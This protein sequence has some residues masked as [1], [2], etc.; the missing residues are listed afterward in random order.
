MSFIENSNIFVQ[1]S[2]SK[3]KQSY[4]WLDLCNIL[5]TTITVIIKRTH[6][7]SKPQLS[8]QVQSTSHSYY[9]HF[10]NSN[11]CI[12][13]AQSR[14]N[15]LYTRLLSPKGEGASGLTTHQTTWD[16]GSKEIPGNW[17]Q[18]SSRTPISKILT[19]VLVKHTKEKPILLSFVN[20]ST[21]S[22]PWFHV[23][24]KK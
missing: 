10:D 7:V 21:I 4:H 17:W 18:A 11:F 2:C 19:V 14:S 13:V 22:F 24:N 23:R 5:V 8:Q 20:L 1:Q 15:Y 6:I 12:S 9:H 16:I 3:T